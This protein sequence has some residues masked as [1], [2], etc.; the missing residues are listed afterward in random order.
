MIILSDKNFTKPPL[1][2]R[3]VLVND[4]VFERLAGED[5]GMGQASRKSFLTKIYEDTARLWHSFVSVDVDTFLR[6]LTDGPAGDR[7]DRV[8]IDVRKK[9]EKDEPCYDVRYRALG[10]D[11]TVLL[12]AKDHFSCLECK[13]AHLKAEGRIPEK[14]E[15]M[16]WKRTRSTVRDVRESLEKAG[17][18]VLVESP[19]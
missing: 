17:F 13:D 7:T 5:P 11:G 12:Y 4:V 8:E 6:L 19:E 9:K 2:R 14:V 16:V 3:I 10:H 18:D 1:R 15:R